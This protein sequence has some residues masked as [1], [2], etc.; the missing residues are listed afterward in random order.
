MGSD[1]LDGVRRLRAVGAQTVAQDAKSCVVYGMPR[2]VAEAGM[3]DE[4]VPIE[5][6]ARVIQGAVEWT[7]KPS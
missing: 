4:V 2:A 6:I 5:E 3:A 7:S 1:G